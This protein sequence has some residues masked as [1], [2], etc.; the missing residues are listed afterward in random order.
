MW[1][2]LSSKL[3]TMDSTIKRIYKFSSMVSATTLS[4]NWSSI[5]LKKEP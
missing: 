2:K 1:S 3:M 4:M 5:C